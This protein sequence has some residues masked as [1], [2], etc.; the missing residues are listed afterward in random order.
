MKRSAARREA[1]SAESDDEGCIAA[2]P[3]TM[4]DVAGPPVLVLVPV[5]EPE[6]EP[7][8]PAVAL[9]AVPVPVPVPVVVPVVPF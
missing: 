3:V 5:E 4:E 8:R 1:N 2:P 9:V 6:E 7:P